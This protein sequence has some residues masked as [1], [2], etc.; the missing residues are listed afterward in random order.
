MFWEIRNEEK[1]V[2]YFERL[3]VMA[4]TE[5]THEAHTAMSTWT[6]CWHLVFIVYAECKCY[7][8]NKFLVIIVDIKSVDINFVDIKFV[9]INFL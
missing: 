9:D 2:N 1:L 5:M 8:K 3:A 7:I 6:S 4:L